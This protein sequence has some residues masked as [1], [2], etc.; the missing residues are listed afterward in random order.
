M[1]PPI[2][3][4]DDEVEIIGPTRNGANMC[5]GQKI[6]IEELNITKDAAYYSDRR[7][8]WYPASSLQLVD[9]GLKIGDW[10]RIDNPE[11]K[12]HGEIFQISGVLLEKS[13]TYL[14]DAPNKRHFAECHLRKLTPEEV[15]Q[16]TD[17]DVAFARM[18]STIER[19]CERLSAIEKRLDVL[20]GEM[21]EVCEGKPD[22]DLIH[23]RI[24]KGSREARKCAKT[25]GEIIDFVRWALDKVTG[26]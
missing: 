2:F 12:S 13:G 11:F 10:V 7:L 21:P 18:A 17:K 1:T 8:P 9:D 15:K 14:S 4:I 20:E 23:V 22:D 16:H 5:R 3:H 25:D 6:V 24:Y 19:C 26:Q